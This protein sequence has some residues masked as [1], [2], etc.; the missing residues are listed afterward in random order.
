MPTIPPRP[1]KLRVIKVRPSSGGPWCVCDDW[2]GVGQMITDDGSYAFEIADLT[3][4]EYDALP[5]DFPGW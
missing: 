5:D 1:A 4:E 3:P 2:D